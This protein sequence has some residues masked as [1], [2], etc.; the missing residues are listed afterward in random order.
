MRHVD[1][2]D[3][4]EVVRGAVNAEYVRIDVLAVHVPVAATATSSSPALFLVG[5]VAVAAR[6]RLVMAQMLLALPG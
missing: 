1:A 6:C 3:E 4:H 5:E 2:E